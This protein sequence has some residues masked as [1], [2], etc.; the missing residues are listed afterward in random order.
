MNIQ[1]SEVT[2]TDMFC[3]CGGSSEG[4]RNVGGT[5]V[6][7][8]LNHWE[9]AIESHNT[10]HPDTHHDCADISETHPARYQRTNFLIASP[11]CTNHTLAAGKR[12]KNLNQGEIF[13]NKLI[14]E[15][16]I[17]SRATMWDVPRFAEQHQYDCIITEN[18]V[19]V[20][21]WVMFDAWLKAMHSL[22]YNHKCVYLNAM[23]A[24]GQEITGFAPQSRDRIYIVFWKKGNKAPD[25]EIRPKAP[26]N[27][28]GVVE[29]V[30]S[31]K[32]GCLPYGKYKTQYIY[33]C[34]V[35]AEPVTPYYYA[36][37]NALDLSMP[38]QKIRDRK[39]PLSDKTMDRIRYGLNKYGLRPTVLDQRNQHGTHESRIRAAGG[40]PLNAQTTG[41][42]SYLF[43]PYMFD[44]SHSHS[45]ADRTKSIAGD[46]MA[47]QTTKN[48]MGI[49]MPESFVIANRAHATPRTMNDALPTVTTR[50]NEL[51][52]LG[53]MPTHH[54]K[55]KLNEFSDPL[56]TVSTMRTNSVL[57]T[58]S[59]ML[60]MRGDRNFS[61][62]TDALPTQVAA[63]IQNY[64]VAAEPFL[65]P[66]HGGSQQAS[67]LTD[68]ASTIPTKDSVYMVE[69][70]KE[71]DPMDC[72]F[73]MIQP[74]ET[75]LAQG[76]PSNYI[77]L[78]NKEDQQ[79][80][81]G[82]ANPPCTMELLVT[83]C[84]QSLS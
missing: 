73:R 58:P 34:S 43:A 66:Y 50:S 81:I 28:C 77:I 72:Y 5:H 16:A 20:R 62:M 64:I 47:T 54:G 3:G 11:E 82:N 40:D 36:A 65:Q 19:D 8:A 69:S 12:R 26:C 32:K 51:S 30:Q 14:D 60:T 55:S 9:K 46:A 79:K 48:N 37:I 22:G 25:L 49:V 57:L 74:K 41:F 38:M 10:N 6:K 42:S 21:M 84:V 56:P 15:T 80:Q 63:A 59:A 61:Q 76:F 1:P 52:L 27:R 83:R 33:R 53:F 29:A 68:P 13:T 75:A 2:I 18:V 35:C 24:H 45:D 4:A 70:Y 78:G 44:M 23:F 67:L 71:I 31:W 17:R 39:V 7:Y